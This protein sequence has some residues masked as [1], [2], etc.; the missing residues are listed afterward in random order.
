MHT[1][2]LTCSTYLQSACPGMQL[3]TQL[4]LAI[5]QHHN[6]R[7]RHKEAFEETQQTIKET[8][9]QAAHQ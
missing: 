5:T 9:E 1:H 8:T 6:G 7:K 2:L 3:L 4:M